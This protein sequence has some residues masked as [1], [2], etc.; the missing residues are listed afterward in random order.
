MGVADWLPKDR[1]VCFTR[2]D[3]RS[4][5]AIR[6]SGL[7]V[8]VYKLDAGEAPRLTEHHLPDAK[9]EAAFVARFH[10]TEVH[11]KCLDPNPALSKTFDPGLAPKPA[12]ARGP[13]EAAP[14]RPA[15]KKRA[16]SSRR[17]DVRARAF[18]G[19]AR[20]DARAVRATVARLREAGAAVRARLGR[21]ASPRALARLAKVL[22]AI[23]PS[24]R[25]I[26][27][28]HDGFDVQ[29]S[30]G[31]T[32]ATCTWLPISRML[33]E[34][35]GALLPLIRQYDGAIV[36]LDASAPRGG[37]LRVV[38]RGR[39]DDGP[40][41]I[42]PSAGALLAALVRRAF[43]HPGIPDVANEAA[44]RLGRSLA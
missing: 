42:A 16:R 41:G 27:R 17:A 11:Y 28:V 39:L 31:D 36:A 13:R 8:L 4:T 20:A 3:G 14:A 12:A 6:R 30:L 1:W 33:A 25:A 34:R 15:P 32:H 38:F 40:R 5:R 29:W 35:E 43:T 21:P 9:S 44:A 22:G 18:T 7:T 23:P 26:L 24:L 10:R 37:E 2:R 19:D